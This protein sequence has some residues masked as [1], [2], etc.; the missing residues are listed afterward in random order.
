MIFTVSSSS[1]SVGAPLTN[2]TI[3]DENGA[4]VAG[5]ID[6]SSVASGGNGLTF[7]DTVTFPT[8]R[9]VYTIKG[10]V[11]SNTANG[12]TIT[13]GTTPSSQWTNV[14][15]QTTGST[16]SLSGASIFS[17]NTMTVK[18]ATL[19]VAISSTPA[20]QNV[21]GGTQNFVLA[22]FQLDASQSGEDIR[23]S[24]FPVT[25]TASTATDLT[26]CQL[27][28]GSTAL[29]TGSRVVNTFTSG[30]AKTYTFDNSL[31]IPKGTVKTLSLACNV[32]STPG[33][34]T[35]VVNADTTNGD[36]TV[37]GATSGNSV[38]TTSG[39]TL[40]ANNGNTMTVGNGS[41]AVSVDSSSPSYTV[42]AGGTTGQTV[43]VMKLRASNEAVNLTK[44]GLI[45]TSGSTTDVVSASIYQ[46]A[47][48]IGT[49]SWT[50]NSLTAT[51]TLNSPLAL[52][53]DTDV[54]LTVK[55]DFQN[56]GTSQPGTQGK[57]VKIDPVNVEG[58][59]ASSGSTLRANASANVAGVRLFKS[60]PTLAL[61]STLGSTGVADGR[62]IRFKATATSNGSVG[63]QQFNFKVSTTS[64]T[65]TN[66]GLYAY[67]DSSYSSPIS[68]QGTS[69]QIGSTA[70]TIPN[71][72][73][74]S[75][76]PSSS[77]VQVPAGSTIYFEL[78]GS[79]AGVVSGSS[80]VTTLLGDSSYPTSYVDT[81]RGYQVATSSAITGS[82]NFVWSG[83]ATST[84]VTADVDWSNGYGLPGLPAS[85]LIQTRSN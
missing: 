27:W 13:L 55:A 6:E 2:V 81:T 83:N 32:A 41:L 77:P 37:T 57:L 54:L 11:A 22:K 66:V 67:T 19:S 76:N 18:A 74:F 70:S 29:N 73:T 58:T 34:T 35:Y 65:V 53:K 5:P 51:S 56:V 8:G 79:V 17:M 61:D 71:N 43:A 9:H 64:A 10:K 69:G 62:L 60:Y 42:V 68:G 50:G 63:I 7:T 33:S 12:A 30:T 36:Y 85:G 52:T 4:V 3:V 26:G 39:L 31:T 15:G 14:T 84:S 38:T 20:A 80:A 23:L 21:V 47:T 25:I 44:I 72:V 46:G 82:Q 40:A 49:A 1:G 78:R 45:L 75:I 16:V 48:L 59:G 24:S 28:D